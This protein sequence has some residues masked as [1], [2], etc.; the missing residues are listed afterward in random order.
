MFAASEGRVLV[1]G[2]TCRLGA[3]PNIRVRVASNASKFVFA[4]VG[5]ASG[6][7]VTLRRRKAVLVEDCEGKGFSRATKTRSLPTC[8]NKPNQATACRILPAGTWKELPPKQ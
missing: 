7:A 1:E 4:A 3:I 5:A 8:N 6:L 2:G